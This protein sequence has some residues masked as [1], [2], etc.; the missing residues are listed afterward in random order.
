MIR[1]LKADR[2]IVSAPV[3]KGRS[4]VVL[5][6]ADY[7]QKT[8]NLLENGHFYDSCET[9]P[10]KTLTRE[11]N[12]TLLALEN[13]RRIST[14]DPRTARAQDTALVRFCGLLKVH[15][16]LAVKTIELLLRRKNDE[17]MKCLGDAQV[18]QLLK[19]CLR[20]YFTFDETIYEQKGFTGFLG[21]GVRT[22]RRLTELEYA[23]N[24]ALLNAIFGELESA[25]VLDHHCLD[26]FFRVKFL[27]FAS[28][29]A[30]RTRCDNILTISRAQFCCSRFGAFAYLE[31]S[32]G[33]NEW[34][35][36]S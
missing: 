6:R 8:K 5:D 17:I 31:A 29:E 4:T 15:K 12:A 27:D 34:I 21:R 23:E 16:D 11:I 2:D 19:F 32:K 10:V 18:L 25:E 28:H 33:R 14:T 9:N 35:E 24:I 26:I 13:S 7:L 22:G 20:T 30:V 3:E 36:L 1:K